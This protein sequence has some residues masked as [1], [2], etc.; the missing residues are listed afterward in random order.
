MKSHI[1][2]IVLPLVGILNLTACDKKS[3]SK[4]PAAKPTSVATVGEAEW[5]AEHGVPESVCTRCNSKLIADFK[6]KG[7]WCKE[8]GLPES[9][10]LQCDPSLKA[11][12][13]AMAPKK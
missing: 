10:C 5:C 11:K 4:E 2:F 8:H 6:Q 3:A 13:E 1:S 12:F 7:D 9:Q